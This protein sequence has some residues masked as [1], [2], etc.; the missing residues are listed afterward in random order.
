MIKMENIVPREGI[1]PTFL[2]FRASVPPLHHVGSLSMQVPASE[3][4]TDY[5][6]HRPEI[7]SLLMLTIT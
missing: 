6:T 2:A 3:V 7:V 1:E 4:S 5:Y